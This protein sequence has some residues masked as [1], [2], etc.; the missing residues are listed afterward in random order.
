MAG[1]MFVAVLSLSSSLH[2]TVDN[3]FAKRRFDILLAFEDNQRL[4]RTVTIA[5]RQA[6]V[7]Q[8]ELVF[9][10]GASL[11]KAG[12]RL[13]EAG[14]GSELIGL[15]NGSDM[16]RPPLL[17]VGRWLRPDD[18]P[19]IVISKDAAGDNGINLG[20]TVTLDLGEFGDAKWQVVGFYSDIFNGVGETD[21]IYA[22]LDAVCAATKK[23]HQGDQIYVRTEQHEA[24]YVQTVASQ[25]KQTYEV[26]SIDVAQSLTEPENR[27][28][29]DSQFDIIIVMFLIMAMIMA[30]VGG[31]GLMGSLSI[32][33]VE[34]TREIGVMRA[35][36][37]K[38]STL[39]GMFVMEG[40]L[41]GLLSWFVVVPLSFILGRPLSNALGEVL[42]DTTLDYQ[43][44]FSA[45][46]L[47]LAI[48]LLIASLASVLPA[49][50]AV[51]IS[52]RE[53]LTYA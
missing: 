17:V 7:A 51:R 10:H 33:V 1:T 22:N 23:Y 46:W 52:V 42:F 19:A 26:K 20:D 39:L 5:E 29:V 41:Q 43:Y 11:L 38:T 36:G 9:S 50:R 24:A 30:I 18:G 12:Q 16:F 4:E 45:I 14:I 3:I 37:A 53:S 47:W 25:L 40:V 32:S 15:P 8:A 27:R 44:N 2:L 48:I 6:G 21:S 13:K 35:I 49:R 28:N 31:I 34:R